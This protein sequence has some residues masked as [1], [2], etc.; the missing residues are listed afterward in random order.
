MS[1]HDSTRD[2]VSQFYTRAVKSGCGCG[3]TCTPPQK[4]EAAKQAG[5]TAADLAGLPEDAVANSFGCGN[6]L[7]FAGVSEGQTVLDLGS[8]AGID[9]L[10][11]AR[12]VGPGGRV[13]GVDMT[14][15]MILRARANAASAGLQN[16][17]VRQGLIEQLPVETAS[18]DWVISNCVVNLSPEKDKVFAEIAR[19]LR[20]GGQVSI[21]DIVVKDL[22]AW[23][24]ESAALYG[25]CVA[26][27]ISEEDYVAGLQ[28]AGLAEVTVLDRIHYDADQLLALVKSE[29]PESEVSCCAPSNGGELAEVVAKALTGRIWSARFHARKA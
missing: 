5:Y 2:K 10:V 21:S 25:A 26:G 3:C 29:L 9:L 19:V 6:P 11:A 22:P 15:E 20:P 8:G 17:E 23:A 27:A 28:A 7:A 12:K 14:D 1:D 24:K 4:G 13:I 16:I 18:V